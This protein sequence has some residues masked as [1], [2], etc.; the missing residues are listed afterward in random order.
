MN[1]ASCEFSIADPSLA[2]HYSGS[3]IGSDEDHYGSQQRGLFCWRSD[4]Y[5]GQR[6][7]S[8]LYVF[9]LDLYTR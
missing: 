9:S 4:S 2:G 6:W 1:C 5:M 7:C 3:A 8:R